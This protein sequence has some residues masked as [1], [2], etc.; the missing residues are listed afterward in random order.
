MDEIDTDYY[1]QKY[2]KIVKI[3]GVKARSFFPSG[4]QDIYTLCDA[5]DACRKERD[6]LTAEKNALQK[7]ADYWKP[8]P[9]VIHAPSGRSGPCIPTKGEKP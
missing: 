3:F 8:T 7:R 9:E 5:L 4:G 6:N 2:Q 1:R